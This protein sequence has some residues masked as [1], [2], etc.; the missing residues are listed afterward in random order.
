MILKVT[1]LIDATYQDLKKLYFLR[2]LVKSFASHVLPFLDE[3]VVPAMHQF[4]QISYFC[5]AA[6]AA[7]TANP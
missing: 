3:A 4:P 7:Y 2:V 1:I 6:Y 5:D